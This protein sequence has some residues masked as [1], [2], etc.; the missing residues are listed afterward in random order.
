MT[1]ENVHRIEDCRNELNK[2]KKWA[3]SNPLD[4]NVNY[5]TSYCIIRSCGTLEIVFKQIVY[6]Y[7]SAGTIVDTQKYLEIEILDSSSNPKTGMME[8]YLDKIDSK[9]KEIFSDKIKSLGNAKSDLN[10]LVQLRNDFAH[11]KTSSTSITII[12]REFESGIKILDELDNVL[13]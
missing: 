8:C 10:S 6:D 1:N 7:L 13:K 3:D 9:K 4:S 12:I 5:L 2:I 11:G